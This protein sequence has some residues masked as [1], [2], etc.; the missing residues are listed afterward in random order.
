DL[1]HETFAK[2]A[3]D[4]PRTRRKN[5]E[6]LVRFVEYRIYE[7]LRRGW[8]VV[9]PNLEQA[10]L[11]RIM[12]EDLGTVC[13]D[14]TPWQRHPILQ[15]AAPAEREWVCRVFLDHLRRELAIS[16]DCLQPDEQQ[17]LV[18]TVNQ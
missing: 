12:Y 2:T 18:R 10:G 6:A 13:A 8:R 16:A 9:Q 11:M 7:D 17:R 1:P 4:V 5:E 15:Q 3:S 14:E